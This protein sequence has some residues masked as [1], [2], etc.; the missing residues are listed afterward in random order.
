MFTMRV[1]GEQC[2]EILPR[3]SSESIGPVPDALQLSGN[4]SMLHEN[5][6][7]WAVTWGSGTE[8]RPAFMVGV[9]TKGEDDCWLSQE[10]SRSLQGTG[11]FYFLYLIASLSREIQARRQNPQTWESCRVKQSF[12]DFIALVFILQLPVLFPRW[13]LAAQWIDLFTYLIRIYWSPT[14]G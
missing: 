1:G 2:S 9:G 4:T 12:K 8:L 14:L 5:M 7:Q 13:N 11:P 10:A 6:H 3:W